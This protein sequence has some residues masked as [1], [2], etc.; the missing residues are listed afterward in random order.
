VVTAPLDLPSATGGRAPARLAADLATSVRGE[1]R[2]DTTS[3]AVFAADASNYR[4][5]PIGVVQPADTDDVLAALEVCRRHLTPIVAR[6][7]GTSIAGQAVNAAVVLDFSRHLGHVLDIDPVAQLARVQPGVVLDELRRQAAPHGLTFGPDPSTHSRCTIGGMIGNNACGSH[8]VAWG[9]TVDN[10]AALDVVTYRGTRLRVGPTGTDELDRLTLG[11]PSRLAPGERETATIYRAL[12]AVR[13]RY[14]AA[15]EA[16]F[17]D[18]TRRVSGYNL[19]QLLPAAGFDLARALVGSEGTCATI[20]EATVHL[21]ES[22]AVRALT[23]LGFPDAYVAADHVLPLLE[24]SPLAMEGIDSGLV[25]ALRAARPDERVTRLLPEGGGWLYIET[26][27]SD[28]AEARAG[29]EAVA[30]RGRALG[31]SALVVTDGP[32]MRQLWRIREDGAGILTRLPDGGEAWP[33]WEDSAVPPARLGSYLRSFTELLDAHRLRGAYYGHFGDGCVHIRIDFDLLSA[34][35]VARFRRFMEEA[36]DLVAIHGGSLSGEHGDGQARAE[37][38]PRMYPPEIIDAFG[39][40]KSAWDPDG[41]MNPRVL[42]DPRPMDEDLRLA[43]GPATINLTTKLAFHADATGFAGA[44]RRC[45]GV[46]KC[47]NASGGVMCP[48]YRATGEEQHSTR[49]RARLLFE[50]ASGNLIEDG[51]RSVEVRDALDLCLGCK[52]CKSDCPVGVDMATYRS[53]FLSHHYA[54][55]RRPASHYSMG[56][57]PL[58]LQVAG[59]LPGVTNALFSHRRASRVIKRLGGIAPERSLPTVATTPF[60]RWWAQR[61]APA[62]PGPDAPRLLLWPDTFSNFFDPTVAQAAVGALEH[63]G[64]RVEVPGAP[65]CCGLTWMSTGQLGMARRVLTRT[66][67]TLRPWIEAGVPVVGLEPSCTEMLRVDAAEVLGHDDLATSLGAAVRSLAQVLDAHPGGLPV[68]VRT[69]RAMAQ[70]HCHQHA[71]PGF[72]TDRGVLTTLGVET[73]V[74]DSGCCGLAGN[75]GFEAGHYDVSQACAERVLL[76]AVRSAAPDVDVLADGFSCRTQIR[77][78]SSG[79]PLHLAQIA[80]RAWGLDPGH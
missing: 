72:D 59:R 26:G 54:G 4:H 20:L 48:S 80:A 75:F 44:T 23:V 73:E 35:G 15:V 12:R 46:G 53:E 56:W 28:D 1:V 7:A 40:F 18:L 49:G 70:V 39:A 27:G 71:G 68:P 65:V 79:R 21:V 34:P 60:T 10:V 9:K 13:D 57:L 37:L 58:S 30:A 66:L 11:D 76:P 14:G 32:T 6:G 2:F 24:L 38:L 64:Y 31:A 52:G 5:V 47:L 3:R 77:Q 22:P 33:G 29:A 19:D 61:P 69:S 67:R 62:D 41:A 50:M 63:L 25:A 42:V 43:T 74:L 16:D 8:S 51:W 45:V 36:A 55:R 78:G 17:P